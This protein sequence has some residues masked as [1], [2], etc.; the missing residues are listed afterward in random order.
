M[1]CIIHTRN[2]P[3]HASAGVEQCIFQLFARSCAPWMRLRLFYPSASTRKLLQVRDFFAGLFGIRY[4]AV[5]LQCYHNSTVELLWNRPTVPEFLVVMRWCCSVI[6]LW[7]VLYH[8][9]YSMYL[10]ECLR[11]SAADCHASAC[12]GRGCRLACHL[13]ENTLA[14]Q[15]TLFQSFMNA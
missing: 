4:S 11:I 9:F 2:F 3:A 13:H 5:T 15:S 12:P 1:S 14:I 7:C 8:A 10:H 6:V